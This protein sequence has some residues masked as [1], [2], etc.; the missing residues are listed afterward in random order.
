[1]RRH[2]ILSALLVASGASLA[3][4]A[5]IVIASQGSAQN[6]GESVLCL[7]GLGVSGCA[8]GASTFRVE[9]PH[10]AWGGPDFAAFEGA[11][12]GPASAW[13]S[14]Q[15]DT[16]AFPF[17]LADGTVNTFAHTFTL[18]GDAWGFLRVAADDSTSVWLNGQL[19]FAEAPSLGNTYLLCSDLPIGCRS[20]N[21]LEL[22]LLLGAGVH[23]L[24]LVA[25][26]RHSVAFGLRY[27]GELTPLS[28]PEPALL[29][30]FGLGLWL[31]RR[32]VPPSG[33]RN[34]L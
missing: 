34:R 11:F 15:P 14:T 28:V 29:A 25:A 8:G 31:G 1:M 27:Y 23:T 17:M 26:Q 4:A 7:G 5:P 9:N 22:P 32:W 2:L 10:P 6:P 20:D 3:H 21:Y 12:G 13:I 19:L 16:G 24:E 18:G 30:V 33:R